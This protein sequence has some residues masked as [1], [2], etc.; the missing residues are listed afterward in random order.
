MTL[1]APK[2]GRA[3]AIPHRLSALLAETEATRYNANLFDLNAKYADV[4]TE[5]DAIEHIDRGWP[6][7]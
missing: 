4:V 3:Y 1:P 2:S 6:S 5:E 7:H